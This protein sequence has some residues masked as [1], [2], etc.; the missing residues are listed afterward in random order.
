ML[1]FVPDFFVVFYI[2]RLSNTEESRHGVDACLCL[3]LIEADKES[4]PMLTPLSF[5]IL[6]NSS[7]RVH[8]QGGHPVFV[9]TLALLTAE[10][11][12]PPEY[13]VCSDCDSLCVTINP[14][15]GGPNSDKA[16]H[17]SPSHGALYVCA[18]L[19][20][21]YKY[22]REL[23]SESHFNDFFPLLFC[24]T[25]PPP[26]TP[27]LLLLTDNLRVE[28]WWR[29]S[30]RR[31]REDTYKA[32]HWEITSMKNKRR[33]LLRTLKIPPVKFLKMS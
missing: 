11:T 19:E 22:V 32:Q 8:S 23:W 12:P 27:Y 1:F 3:A 4:P 31:S 29:H 24:P 2:K 18:F 25:P 9:F 13:S 20:A 28:Q 17:S 15:W 21:L 33:D 16:L 26:P 6:A 14:A 7:C 10:P 5:W 30:D